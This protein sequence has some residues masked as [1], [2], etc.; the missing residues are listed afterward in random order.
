MP[1]AGLCLLSLVFV[2]LLISISFAAVSPEVT[3]V[4]VSVQGFPFPCLWSCR[5]WLSPSGCFGLCCSTLLYAT[6]LRNTVHLWWGEA[7][8][9]CDRSCPEQ[10]CVQCG[11]CCTAEDT[12][13]F[14][15]FGRWGVAMLSTG[16]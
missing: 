5:G 10:H 12:W 14:E 13:Q 16:P 6:S 3:V 11:R 2:V 15:G 9:C 4:F 7:H 1:L 8:L